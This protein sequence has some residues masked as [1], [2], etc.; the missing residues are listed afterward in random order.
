[1]DASNLPGVL[2]AERHKQT[3]IMLASPNRLDLITEKSPPW[4]GVWHAL[5]RRIAHFPLGWQFT[6]INNIRKQMKLNRYHMPS[7][8]FNAAV[9]VFL[10]PP[11]DPTIALPA[12]IRPIQLHAP[13]CVFCDRNFPV[14]RNITIAIMPM[15]L[16]LKDARAI[17][18]GIHLARMS[19]QQQAIMAC[20]TNQESHECKSFQARADLKA[21]MLVEQWPIPYIPE[22]VPSFLAV[23]SSH[24]LDAISRHSGTSV[25]ISHCNQFSTMPAMA[26][27]TLICIPKKGVPLD[28]FATGGWVTTARGNDIARS[29]IRGVMESNKD[30]TMIKIQNL[31]NA[32]EVLE[33]LAFI[34][35][36]KR[37][38]STNQ[39]QLLLRE[40]L[41][42]FTVTLSS[43]ATP[44]K[45]IGTYFVV[46][47]LLLAAGY[48]LLFFDHINDPSQI[49]AFHRKYPL[50]SAFFA[51][52][53]H[54]LIQF[55]Q[56]LRD[57][58]S[59]HNT[60][61]NTGHHTR[62]DGSSDLVP[63]QKTSK[64]R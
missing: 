5:Q 47:F 45:W 58:N 50:G 64:K 31:S 59:F 33:L 55:Q 28:A 21:V 3:I 8:F 63:K 34:S 10:Y 57:D 36:E 37:F 39:K 38:L 62:K 24:I 23:E 53:D 4:K 61:S 29:V 51:E 22:L 11:I 15:D 42:I 54:G 60:L 44:L 2:W 32:I 35:R 12:H 7:D 43:G 6:E 17:I 26:G 56:W 49:P 46:G 25:V 13:Q 40:H 9:E 1:M 41:P 52:L 27:M 30:D 48:T 16:S 14:C 19:F 20:E 18:R